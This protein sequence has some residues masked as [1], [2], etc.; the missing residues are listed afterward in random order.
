[1]L[2][3]RA[4]LEN[5]R[6]FLTRADLHIDG[7]I[8]ILIGP[9]GGGKT[10]LLDA[11]MV[12]LRRYVFSSMYAAHEPTAEQRDRYV[13]RQNDALNQMQL[14]KHSGG[15]TRPQTVEVE[16]EATERDVENMKAMQA[17]AP[18]LEDLA[19]VKYF[20]LGLSAAATWD[21]TTITPGA[22]FVYRLQDGSFQHDGAP[23]TQAFLQYLKTYE[24]DSRL[25]DE[26]GLA[27]LSTPLIYL[28]VNRAAAG[29]QS[30]I[31]LAGFNEFEMKRQSD[32]TSSRSGTQIVGLSIGRLAQ[33]YRLLLEKDKGTA[34]K[35]FNEDPSLKEMT[36][37]L[38][39][40]GYQWTLESINPLRN[41]Y[42]IRL[43]KQGSSF[44]VGAASSGEREL[45]TYLFAIF[46][47][48]V[49][50]ALIIVDEPELHLHPKWQKILLGMFARLTETTG[51]QFL[52]A[53][54]SPTFVSP[55]SIQY[56]SRVFSRNQNSQIVR[57]NSP[58]P[59][60][61]HLFN[62]INSQ[63]NESIFFADH[64]VLVEG[65]SDR[66]LFETILDALGR[67]K[68]SKSIL[69][70]V[71]IGGK[72]FFPAYE[73]VLRACNIM[74]SVVADLDY[75]EQ[76]GDASLKAL[77]KLN[78]KEVK[79][80]VID[81][82]KSMDADSLVAAISE[83]IATGTWDHAK[84]IWDYIQSRRRILRKDLKEADEVKLQA[85]L[86]SKRSERIYILSKG[87]LETY[88]PAGHASKDLDKLIRLVAMPNF[89]ELLPE[90]PRKELVR[91]A[92]ALLQTSG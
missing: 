87:A 88:L 19:K 33:K 47:L 1:M 43:D 73:K 76:I 45:L 12:M 34:R 60:I 13:F 65:L 25:R 35:D 80:D 59:D 56:V 62:I 85:F 36:N 22:R 83:A 31:E 91:I 39:D 10:N 11:V 8:S 55:D 81:N 49:R 70:I 6:S 20:G 44:L 26:F 63:N 58:L 84:D 37:L 41:Q 18:R 23:G 57:L 42:D 32:A 53:T 51:N 16:L 4:S 79:D 64:V 50:D 61:R 48:N 75:V 90:E 72:G 86:E 30:S 52:L 24:I 77:F 66:I 15:Q 28:P 71:S 68:S 21:L 5:V 3:R 69:E 7:A 74:Y 38:A 14:E 92:E 82:I 17:D 78:A 46:A 27:P 2:L 9:N 67:G 89:L 29:F 54:H 40:L